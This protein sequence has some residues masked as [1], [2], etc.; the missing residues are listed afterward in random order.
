[1]YTSDTA[2][3]RCDEELLNPIKTWDLRN[4]I[5]YPPI[6]EIKK[7]YEDREE[8]CPRLQPP[9]VVHSRQQILVWNWF[10]V[11]IFKTSSSRNNDCPAGWLM[12]AEEAEVVV[13][14]SIEG[15]LEAWML[16]NGFCWKSLKKN[17]WLPTNR[18]AGRPTDHRT[19]LHIQRYEGRIIF[20]LTFFQVQ[21]FEVKKS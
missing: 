5:V 10:P 9:F 2:T 7:Y 13:A 18:L 15:P 14:C 6:E 11:S 12:V 20:F 8:E 19:D 4:R 21:I 17:N 3:N 16:C 1:M